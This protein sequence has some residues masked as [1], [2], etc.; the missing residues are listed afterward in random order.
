M[1]APSW[2]Q[3]VSRSDRDRIVC[4]TDIPLCFHPGD[5]EVKGKTADLGTEVRNRDGKGL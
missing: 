1:T 2:E 5:V 3:G 4:V